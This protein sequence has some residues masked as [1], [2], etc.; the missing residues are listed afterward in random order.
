MILTTLLKMGQ[1]CYNLYDTGGE[2]AVFRKNTR[3]PQLPLTSHA[4]EL[5]ESLQQRLQNSRAETCYQEFFCCLDEAPFAVLY[6]DIP[7]R[8]NVTVNVLVS[9]GV[10]QSRNGWTDE[11]MYNKLCYQIQVRYA[12]GY[13]YPGKEYFDLRTLYYFRERLAHHM[14]ETSENVRERAFAQMTGPL[15]LSNLLSNVV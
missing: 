3:H 13:R 6:A 10:P 2:E 8:L 1:V 12:L 9:L 14:Q 4:D 5:P 7:S 11:E 15:V